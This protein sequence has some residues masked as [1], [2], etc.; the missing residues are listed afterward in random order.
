MNNLKDFSNYVGLI[1]SLL[2]LF[3]LQ[4]I[5]N[6]R[7][8]YLPEWISLVIIVLGIIQGMSSGTLIVFYIINKY[9]LQTKIG[10]RKFL[11]DNKGKY[12]MI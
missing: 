8:P 10:W 6:Y 3:S 1:I 4:K 7:D 9:A 12:K 5:N 11:K 2:Q